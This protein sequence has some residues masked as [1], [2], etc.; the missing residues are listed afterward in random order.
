MRWAALPHLRVRAA[1]GASSRSLL[2]S[3]DRV[4]TV[5]SSASSPS[6]T[7]APSI[8]Y[9][10]VGCPCPVAS[11]SRSSRCVRKPAEFVTASPRPA[12][13]SPYP[14]SSLNLTS[15]SSR[16][17]LPAAPNPPTNNSW[18]S[19]GKTTPC[20]AERH[21]PLLPLPNPQTLTPHPSTLP[22]PKQHPRLASNSSRAP[23]KPSPPSPQ[24]PSGAPPGPASPSL[25]PWRS[26]LR[27]AGRRGGIHCAAEL[28]NG[29]TDGEYLILN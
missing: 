11:P 12:L 25:A 2:R 26:L 3:L 14:F 4:S 22:P 17:Q 10:R 23:G 6:S 21:N 20:P 29:Q 13:L 8:C 9:D 7:S 1:T 24:Q 15:S 28:Q 27:S 5:V 19:R 18:T 16:L